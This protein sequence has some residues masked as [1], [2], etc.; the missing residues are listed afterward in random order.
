MAAIELAAWLREQCAKY[1]FDVAGVFHRRGEEHD[2]PL[3][4]ANDAGLE[5]QLRKGGHLLPLPKMP[6]ESRPGEGRSGDIPISR[7]PARLSRPAITPLTS[8]SRAGTPL[9]NAAG[10]RAASLSTPGT[11]TSGSRICIGRAPSVRSRTT[12]RT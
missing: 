8:K 12:P 11:R 5:A 3:V 4:A 10:R 9:E 2:W 6:M 7:S 1:I